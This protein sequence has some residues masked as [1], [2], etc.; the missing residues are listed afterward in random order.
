VRLYYFQLR[1]RQGRAYQRYKLAHPGYE[2]HVI[3]PG[4]NGAPRWACDEKA[5]ERAEVAR[6]NSR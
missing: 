2:E 4:V 1:R 5:N 3:D 6:G